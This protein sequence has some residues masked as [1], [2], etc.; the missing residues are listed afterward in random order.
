[1]LAERREELETLC[2][3]GGHATSTHVLRRRKLLGLPGPLVLVVVGEG[4]RICGPVG[5]EVVRGGSMVEGVAV[6]V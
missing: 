2:L 4:G 5:G 3:V 6:R 1:M